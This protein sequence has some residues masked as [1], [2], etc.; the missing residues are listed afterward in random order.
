MFGLELLSGKES[1]CIVDA[2]SVVLSGGQR[3][4]NKLETQSRRLVWFN[5]GTLYADMIRSSPVRS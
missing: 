1:P 5:D 4:S 3:V 2:T